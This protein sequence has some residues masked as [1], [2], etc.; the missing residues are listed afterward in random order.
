MGGVSTNHQPHPFDGAHE[1]EIIRFEA[2][3]GAYT[4]SNDERSLTVYGISDVEVVT[5]ELKQRFGKK[6]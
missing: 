2:K 6:R 3:A 5:A 1:G 4:K